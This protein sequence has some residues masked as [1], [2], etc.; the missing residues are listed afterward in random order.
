MSAQNDQLDIINTGRTVPLAEMA[1]D[2]ILLPLDDLL[3]QYGAALREKEGELLKANR[4][5]GSIYSVPANLYC[6]GNSGF[7]YNQDMA[8]EYGIQVSDIM[9]IQDIESIAATLKNHEKYLLSQGDGSNNPILLGTF[10]PSVVPVGSSMYANGVSLS[11]DS[12]TD[13]VNVFEMEE[14]L[15]YCQILRRWKENGWIPG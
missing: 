2:G 5:D 4:I 3:E 7:L 11:G 10:F 15:E 13:I 14:Y 1:A 8:S 9:S 6:G 12:G